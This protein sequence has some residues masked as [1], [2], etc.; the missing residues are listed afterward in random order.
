M[1]ME[2]WIAAAQRGEKNG[3]DCLLGACQQY[4]LMLAD[5][6]LDSFLR[7]RVAP[8]DVVQD[9]LNDA[10]R[11]FPRFVGHRESDFLAWLVRIYRNN[12]TSLRLYHRA[13]K[14]D[15]RRDVRWPEDDEERPPEDVGDTP[16]RVAQAHEEA[17][18]LDAALRLLPPQDQTVIE[19]HNR[20]QLTFEQVGVRLGCSS[21]AARKRWARA[22]V[23]L[24]KL[25]EPDH[26]ARAT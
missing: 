1:P 17:R 22:I 20:E 4:L 6:E 15:V 21:E 24:Q 2:T 9:T 18:R 14:R 8:S 25:L 5:E 13:G 7:A 16:S 12:L 11:D 26:V 10:M 23:A 19:L 3:L